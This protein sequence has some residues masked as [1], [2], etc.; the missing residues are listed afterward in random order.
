MHLQLLRLHITTVNQSESEILFDNLMGVHINTNNAQFP[1]DLNN[2]VESKIQL[3]FEV[4][5]WHHC[6]QQLTL[7]NK[8]LSMRDSAGMKI[9]CDY[10]YW[11]EK[12]NWNHSNWPGPIFEDSQ[13]FA[14][15]WGHI[16]VE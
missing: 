14:G 11:R 13:N 3:L 6:Q 2:Q 10:M 9:N 4:G 12:W 16:L 7:N 8:V 15:A 5:K 1:S